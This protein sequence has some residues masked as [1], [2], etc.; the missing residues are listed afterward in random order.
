[1]N[2][3]EFEKICPKTAEFFIWR[4]ENTPDCKT[5]AGKMRQDLKTIRISNEVSAGRKVM[6]ANMVKWERKDVVLTCGAFGAWLL[7]MA[8]VFF[9]GA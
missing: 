6:A 4:Y 3:Q 2:T 5:M 7:G 8:A 9:G 1:M